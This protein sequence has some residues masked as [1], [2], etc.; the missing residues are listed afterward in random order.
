MESSIFLEVRNITKLF[1]QVI[2]NRRVS[3]SINKGE[4]VALLG[5]NG[6]GKSTIMKIVYGLYRPDS[7][8]LYVEGKKQKNRVSQ[9]SNGAWHFNDPATLFA[10]AGTYSDRKCHIGQRKRNHQAQYL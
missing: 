10:G 7:G 8:E 6:A 2:A 5:E 4:V 9:A 1:A 3:F